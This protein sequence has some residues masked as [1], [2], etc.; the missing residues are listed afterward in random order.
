M[1][2]RRR[3]PAAPPSNDRRLRGGLVIGGVLALI[4]ILALVAVIIASGD[5]DDGGDGA[6]SD[7]SSVEGG[8]GGDGAAAVEP[9]EATVEVSGD[10]LPPLED[11]NNDAAIGSPAPALAGTNYQGEPVEV[12]PGADGPTMVVFL[13][14]WCPHCNDEIPVLNEWRDSGQIPDNLRIVGVSTAASDQRPNYPPSE[15]LVEKDW[16][17]D[18]IADSPDARAL[19]AYGVTGFP[20]FALLDAEGNVVYRGS[21]EYPIEVLSQLAAS[22][23]G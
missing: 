4:A 6:T 17:W 10:N 9:H 16:Q 23:T 18:V 12:Q 14:H 3:P 21:G 11:P 1:N 13:A 20:F 19:E 15:W 8:D 5:D 7:V 22:V 2:Q